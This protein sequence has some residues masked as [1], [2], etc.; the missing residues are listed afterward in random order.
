MSAAVNTIFIN[1]SL[2]RS[3]AIRRGVDIVV[4]PSIDGQG[5]ADTTRWDQGFM[6]YADSNHNRSFDSGEA[7]L[8]HIDSISESIHISSTIKRKKT[9]YNPYGH[10]YGYNLTITFCDLNNTADPAAVIVNNSGRV[11]RTSTNSGGEILVC[12]FN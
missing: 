2:A 1:L 10:V 3:E 6:M 5:C 8:R 9:I 7:I 4:C 11:R 12:S